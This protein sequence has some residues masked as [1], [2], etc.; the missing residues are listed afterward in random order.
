V[1]FR[2]ELETTAKLQEQG[3]E[4]IGNTFEPSEILSPKHFDDAVKRYRGR[5]GI[6]GVYQRVRNGK[7]EYLVAESKATLNPQ[8][9][10]ATGKGSLSATDAGDQL[11]KSWIRGNLHKTG[12]SPA[13]VTE[14]ES[15]L[16][17]DKVRLVYS[18]TRGKETNLFSVVSKTD[19]EATIVGS[20][21]PSL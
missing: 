20:F 11:S 4:P 1:L 6:D 12:L 15:A 21:D 16:A 10:L 19:M 3:W 8:A 14:I 13:E 7:T 18:Q 9:E 5:T 17:E 2:S